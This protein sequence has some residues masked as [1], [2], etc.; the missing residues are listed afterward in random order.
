[1]S[2]QVFMSD[3]GHPER[4]WELTLSDSE[5]KNTAPFP[6]PS[7]PFFFFFFLSTSYNDDRRQLCP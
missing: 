5:A 1:V 2:A 3:L 7:V 6:T 4:D